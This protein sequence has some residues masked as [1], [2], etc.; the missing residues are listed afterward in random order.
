MSGDT[1]STGG[2]S[3]ENSYTVA[4]GGFSIGGWFNPQT[5]DK[6]VFGIC[7][8]AGGGAT[9]LGFIQGAGGTGAENRIDGF[10]YNGSF[11]TVAGSIG[12][13]STLG[14][15]TYLMAVLSGTTNAALT[16]YSATETGPLVSVGMT[17]NFS[18][19]G[20]N[21]SELG[22]A[23]GAAQLM[24]QLMRGCGL[25]D[26]ALTADEVNAQR[27]NPN[28]A[29]V[30]TANCISYMPIVDGT[31]PEVAT[32]GGNGA[33]SGAFAASALNPYLPGTRRGLMGVGR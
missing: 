19:N 30:R 17:T 29:A 12:M 13:I 11:N 1:Q 4:T 25:W 28:F 2:N 6:S 18:T 9:A 10:W 15:W 21:Y 8:V 32:T 26:V 31:N 3:I 14:S 16:L 33:L 24:H 27:L 22:G 23:P 7:C 20:L 5:W